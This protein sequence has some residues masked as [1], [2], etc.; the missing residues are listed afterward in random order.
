MFVQ[1]EAMEKK[2]LHLCV[3]FLEHIAK[4]TSTVV[5]ELCAEQCNL[6]DNVRKH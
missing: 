5:L 3:I 1:M 2:S 4:M 6:N